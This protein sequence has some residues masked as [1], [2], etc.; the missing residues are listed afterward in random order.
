MSH[1]Q[2]LIRPHFQPRQMVIAADLQAGVEYLAERLRRHNRYLHGCGVTC[3]LEVQ[4]DPIFEFEQV[5]EIRVRAA[6]GQAISPQGDLTDS[7][8]EPHLVPQKWRQAPLTLR[9]ATPV[10][11]TVCSAWGFSRQ[12][13]GI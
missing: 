2:S 13:P 3:G 6:P 12:A 7:P 9:S 11:Q 8:D 10:T 5:R 4:V 1:L